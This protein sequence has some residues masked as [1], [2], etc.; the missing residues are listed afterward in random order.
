M[1]RKQRD[2]LRDDLVTAAEH[3]IRTRGF[4]A[5][6]ARSLATT[7]DCAVGTIYNVFD[8]LHGLI[9]E[10]NGRTLSR[11]VPVLAEARQ[12]NAAPGDQLTALAFSYVN[13][14]SANEQL[15]TAL[16][17][18]HLPEGRRLPDWYHERLADLFLQ[19]ELA[20]TPLFRNRDR[21][22]HVRSARILWSSLHGLCSLILSD[23]LD[24][25]SGDNIETLT[26]DM[27][28]TYLAGI[29]ATR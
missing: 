27:I 28:H 10:V 18:Y 19:V 21:E 25:V 14:I 9:I 20:I 4:T 17:Q 6:T 13:F 12:A 3:I 26:E 16:M 7:G 11:L 23:K 8:D 5:L 24:L 2:G 22:D 15:W 29:Q 1:P